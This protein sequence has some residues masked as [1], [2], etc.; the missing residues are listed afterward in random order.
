VPF[1]RISDELN[2]NSKIRRLVSLRGGREALGLWTIADS[3]C[4]QQLTDGH[5]PDFMVSQLGGWKIKH[6]DLLVE[7][8]LWHRTEAGFVFH[9]WEDFNESRAD[10]LR[11]RAKNSERQNSTRFS[12]R[13][14]KQLLRVLSHSDTQRDTTRDSTCDSSVSHAA[15]VPIQISSSLRS[16]EGAL[17]LFGPGVSDGAT[18][19]RPHEGPAKPLRAPTEASKVKEA[20]RHALDRLAASYGLVAPPTASKAHWAEGAHKVRAL[21][22]SGSDPVAA[23]ERV[24]RAALDR[25][26]AG[27]SS[28]FGYAL[29]DCV[30]TD[31]Q[32]AESRGGRRPPSPATT[33]KDF[34]D[35]EDIETQVARWAND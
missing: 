18:A 15:P 1:G 14:D 25:L 23:S 33:G 12:K 3:W 10:V 22:A 8:G 2:T 34:E 6:A 28:S 35:A 29:Q 27:R 5:V 4:N 30:I 13:N 32:M 19:G 21:V 24:V 11:K 9:D 20:L 31:R 26:T 7:V 16:E 17:C